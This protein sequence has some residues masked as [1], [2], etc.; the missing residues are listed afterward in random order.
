MRYLLRILQDGAQI[1][2]IIRNQTSKMYY[3]PQ[4]LMS[5]AMGPGFTA[6]ENGPGR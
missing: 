3:S 4:P 2:Y 5:E 1:N 6:D